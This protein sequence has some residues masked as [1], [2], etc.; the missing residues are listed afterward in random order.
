MHLFSNIVSW[1][2]ITLFWKGTF[3]KKKSYF[4]M[5]KKN[6]HTISLAVTF[7]FTVLWNITILN[8]KVT[9]FLTKCMSRTKYYMCGSLIKIRSFY[10]ALFWLLCLVTLLWKSIWDSSRAR[11]WFTLTAFINHF[12]QYAINKCNTWFKCESS[13]GLGLK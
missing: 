6:W 5:Y 1:H 13:P 4:K 8:H 10:T 7:G 3:L 11:W 9:G 2:K 12:L